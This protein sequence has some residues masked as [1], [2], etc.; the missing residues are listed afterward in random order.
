MYDYFPL[1]HLIALS[2]CFSIVLESLA[3]GMAHVGVAASTH[4]LHIHVQVLFWFVKQA[5]AQKLSH[6]AYIP[7]P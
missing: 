6:F 1:P 7:T 3:T 2:N 5:T 4:L